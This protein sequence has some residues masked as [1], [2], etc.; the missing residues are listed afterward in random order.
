MGSE[1]RR[2]DCINFWVCRGTRVIFR[3]CVF[4]YFQLFSEVAEEGRSWLATSSWLFEVCGVGWGLTGTLFCLVFR[5]FWMV[6]DDNT[7][8]KKSLIYRTTT[9]EIS[10]ENRRT[11]NRHFY[12]LHISLGSYCITVVAPPLCCVE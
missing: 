10:L 4:F 2:D 8:S 3:D 9:A 12:C 6:D 5:K 1:D 7:L 11:L